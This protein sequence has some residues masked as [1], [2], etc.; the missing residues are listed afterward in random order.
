[1]LRALCVLSEAAQAP[2]TY[3]E[4]NLQLDN[5]ATDHLEPRTLNPV[6]SAWSTTPPLP[7]ARFEV[8]DT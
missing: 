1:M 3:R 6:S 4:N 5:S 7:T 2:T 8:K